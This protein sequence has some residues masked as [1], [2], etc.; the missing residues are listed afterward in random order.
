MIFPARSKSTNHVHAFRLTL[1]AKRFPF[2]PKL[3][4]EH[5]RPQ[6]VFLLNTGCVFLTMSHSHTNYK[7]AN[8]MKP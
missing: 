7:L 5:V 8:I 1:T 4:I 2:I 3:C 6:Y